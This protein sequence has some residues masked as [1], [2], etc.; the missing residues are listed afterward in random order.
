MTIFTLLLLA[1]TGTLTPARPEVDKPLSWEFEL[2]EKEVASFDEAVEWMGEFRA[3]RK[4]WADFLDTMEMTEMAQSQVGVRFIFT[5]KD[6]VWP[7]DEYGHLWYDNRFIRED[8]KPGLE[9]FENWLKDLVERSPYAGFPWGVEEGETITFRGF[10]DGRFQAIDFLIMRICENEDDVHPRLVKSMLIEDYFETYPDG[11]D[12]DKII[13]ELEKVRKL[14]PSS[15]YAGR[16]FKRYR[17]PGT[18]VPVVR[19]KVNE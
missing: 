16:V 15:K 11:L 12:E 2:T 6:T 13:Y 18:F 3:R 7:F 5:Y 4:L 9:I 8:E 17:N 19:R 10:G 14:D 1:V